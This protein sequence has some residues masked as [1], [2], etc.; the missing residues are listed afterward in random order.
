MKKVNGDNVLEW[1]KKNTR[2]QQ[3]AQEGKLYKIS[4][5][6]ASHKEANT[7]GVDCIERVHTDYKWV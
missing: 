3:K 5:D 6:L 7:Y 4:K 2:T 1:D